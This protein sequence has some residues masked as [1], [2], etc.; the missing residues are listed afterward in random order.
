TV[1]HRASEILLRA[2]ARLHRPDQERHVARQVRQVVFAPVAFLEFL[3]MDEGVV[4][5][6][7]EEV[8]APALP[9]VRPVLD[10]PSSEHFGDRLQELERDQI[11]ARLAFCAPGA[12]GETPYIKLPFRSSLAHYSH[13]LP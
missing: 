13:I 3:E 6:V 4:P 7:G 2:Y 9:V 5:G 12:A 11:E 8:F 10:G 1:L